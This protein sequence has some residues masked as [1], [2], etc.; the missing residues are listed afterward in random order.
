[1][2]NDADL[3][4]LLAGRHADP[5]SRLGLH[6]DDNGRLWVRVLLPGAQDVAVLDAANVDLKAFTEDFYH[7]LCGSH[8]K[9]VLE[10]LV[11]LKAKTKVWVG[12][13]IE[14]QF[15]GMRKYRRISICCS[16]QHKDEM[17]FRYHHA[18]NR[19]VVEECTARELHGGN[20]AKKFIS[21][22]AV[23]LGMVTQGVL[24]LRLTG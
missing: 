14:V 12:V 19:N 23:E 1:M 15:S 24:H 18:T 8:L 11:W 10:T 16:N 6:A 7:N 22:A 4:A 20:E 3:D 21:R 13:S 9:D 17:P 2:L 5:F